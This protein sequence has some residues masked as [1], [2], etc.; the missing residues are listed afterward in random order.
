MLP[1]P[2]PM[3][4][5]KK[6]SRR[7]D[8]RSSRQREVEDEAQVLT[9]S[10]SSPAAPMPS[11]RRLVGDDAAVAQRDAPVGARGQ[12]VVVRDEDERRPVAPVHLDHEVEDVPAVARVEVARRLVGQKDRRL[13]GEGARDGHA[14]LL[15]ARELRRIVVRARRQLH[16]FE[17]SPRTF[18]RVAAAGNL[19][20]REHV[21]KRRHRRDEVEGLEDEAELAAAEPRQRVLAHARNLFAVDENAPRRRRVKPCDETEQSGLAAARRPDD[22]DEL[23]VG[24]LQVKLAQDGQTLRA[25]LNGL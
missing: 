22:G 18:A 11:R 3:H 2:M 23:A 21:L 12:V 17:E 8:A 24:N 1:T 13:V 15:A 9:S 20:R 10:N 16:V 7:H 6:S 5:K 19:Q 25:G 14:L 4:R